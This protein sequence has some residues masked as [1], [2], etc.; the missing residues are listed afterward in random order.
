MLHIQKREEPQFLTDFKKKYPK[1]DYDSEEFASH[2]PVLKSGLIE[3]Q[4]GLCADCFKAGGRFPPD[5]ACRSDVP[6]DDR[7]AVAGNGFPYRQ[8]GSDHRG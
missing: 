8:S 2:R 5:R 3:E 6:G 4:K 1:K 7:E